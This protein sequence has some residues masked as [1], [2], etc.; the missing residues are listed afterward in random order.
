MNPGSP[1]HVRERA[2]RIGGPVDAGPLRASGRTLAVAAVALAI[3]GCAT[4]TGPGPEPGPAPPPDRAAPTPEDE[5]RDAAESVLDDV[6]SALRAGRTGAAA[7]LADSLYFTVRPRPALSGTAA[8]ALRWEARALEDGGELRTAADRLEELVRRYPD[9]VEDADLRRLA[10]LHVSLVDDPAAVALLTRHA[11]ALDDST[12]ALLGVAAAAMSVDELRAALERATAPSAA[13][14]R[15][16]LR[17]ELAVALARAGR[18]DSAA[19]VARSGLGGELAAGHRARARAVLAGEVQPPDGPVRLGALLPLSGR[20]ETVGQR[21]RQGMEIA[22]EEHAR[23]GGR[24]VE[25]VIEDEAAATG[26]TPPL[27]RLEDA[28]VAALLGPV[29]SEALVEAAR[30]RRDSGLLLLSPTATRM[31]AAT[32]ATYTLWERERRELD[33]AGALGRWVGRALEE[34]PAGAVYPDEELGRRAVLAFWRGVGSGGGV[35][36]T[37]ASPFRPRATTLE[38]PITAVSAFDPRAVFAPAM[39]TGSVLQLAPQLSYFGLRSALVAGGPH[40][41]DPSTLRRL[42]PSFTQY[43]IVAAFVNRREG[44]GPWGRFEATYEKKY[45]TSLSGNMLPALGYDAVLLVLRAI[46]DTRPARPR[47]VARA[48]GRLAGVEGA[49]GRLRP[50][51]STGT[52]AREVRIQTIRDRSLAPVTTAAVREWMGAATRLETADARR[53]RQAALEAVRNMEL[54]LTPD[55]GGDG[56]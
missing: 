7:I 27:R 17:T 18:P 33:A 26:L 13:A 30:A 23:G 16:L 34:G 6:R 32:P 10:R 25:L 56:R 1:R 5:L 52:V 35:W 49:T 4:A 46:S 47:A 42:E 40:W 28:G 15:S 36:M 8:E 24:P 29:R 37:A 21:I 12:R 55:E 53:R 39:A 19:A 11:A 54:P 31:D 44:D 45:R 38:D 3:A 51:P 41:S 50:D 22:L 2:S 14:V 9:H 20:F 48:L 43:R